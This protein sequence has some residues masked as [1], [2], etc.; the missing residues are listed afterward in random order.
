MSMSKKQLLS[1]A[2]V[3]ANVPFEAK[4]TTDDLET[5]HVRAVALSQVLSPAPVVKVP[6]VKAKPEASMY[7]D[8]DLVDALRTHVAQRNEAREDGTRKLTLK[9]G[10]N[11]ALRMYLGLDKDDSNVVQL[12]T[13][14]T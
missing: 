2:L 7:A 14:A 5:L 9:A 4:A 8:R 3:A 10:A 11:D 13:S 6:R 12:D 1:A